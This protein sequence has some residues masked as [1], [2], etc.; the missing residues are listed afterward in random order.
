MGIPATGKPV[1]VWGI[2]IDR[3]EEGRIKETRI[4]MDTIGLMMQF[5][6]IPPPGA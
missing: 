3:L 6:A 1:Q 2:V 4:I 5:G